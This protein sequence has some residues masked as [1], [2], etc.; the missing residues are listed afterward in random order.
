MG[1][2]ALPDV[3]DHARAQVCAE[4][5]LD[6][7][8]QDQEDQEETRKTQDVVQELAVVPADHAVE[9]HLVKEGE[10][11]V[12]AHLHQHTQENQRTPGP[13]RTQKIGEPSQKS[14]R[15]HGNEWDLAGRV[16]GR[17]G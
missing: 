14:K 15:P 4:V 13:V 7:F 9:H 8:G 3:A 1:V 2:D 12:E 6:Q 16:F 10:E 17:S 5:P 11:H